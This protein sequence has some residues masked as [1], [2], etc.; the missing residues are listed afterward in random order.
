MY[1]RI[2]TL[3]MLVPLKSDFNNCMLYIFK[4]DQGDVRAFDKNGRYV[5]NNIEY[6]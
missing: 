6:V 3:D 2:G 4:V 1:L 5:L